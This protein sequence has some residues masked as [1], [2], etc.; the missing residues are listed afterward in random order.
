[1]RPALALALTV[2]MLAGAGCGSPERG[3]QAS[4][5]PASSPSPPASSARATAR[6]GGPL[7]V[8]TLGDSI[9][10]GAPGWDPDPAIRA[11]LGQADPRSQYQ[12][13]AQR[14]LGRRVRLRNC[15]VS[16]ETT[17]Q[18]AQRLDACVRGARAL[19]V[20]GGLN[21]IALGLPVEVAARNLEAMVRRGKARGLRVAVAELLPWNDGYPAAAPAV[22]RLNRL[23]AAI[24]RRQG[25]KVLR[26]HDALADP[27]RPGRMR[28]DWT[29]DGDHPSIVGYRRMGEV[30]E[31]P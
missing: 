19:I 2:A 14:R 25:V 17:E 29:S 27:R 30:V 15:G 28:P 20:Q 5:V 13:W 23:I 9:T 4:A 22:A 3:G 11:G 26:F 18:I 8:A 21:D 10:A 24:A 7:L 31:L 6:Q 12:F 1:M 16:G